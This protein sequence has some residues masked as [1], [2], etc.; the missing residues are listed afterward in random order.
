LHTSSYS[1][2]KLKV[3][4]FNLLGE[5]FEK[6]GTY[7]FAKDFGFSL[8]ANAKAKNLTPFLVASYTLGKTSLRKKQATSISVLI[9]FN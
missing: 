4:L 5:L 8:F 9:F 2:I 7:V 1:V 3:E 6:I